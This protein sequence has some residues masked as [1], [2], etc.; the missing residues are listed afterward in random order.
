[1]SSTGVRAC[2]RT[3]QITDP[4]RVAVAG[5]QGPLW[6]SGMALWWGGVIYYHHTESS[7]SLA[8]SFCT[9]RLGSSHFSQLVSQP[10][11]LLFQSLGDKNMARSQ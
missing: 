8:R 3:L 6:S 10:G 2:S 5:G 7:S 1:M 4:S 9:T 11:C